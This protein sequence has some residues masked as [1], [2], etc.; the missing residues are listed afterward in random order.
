MTSKV[1]VRL[2]NENQ[3]VNLFRA[4]AGAEPLVVDPEL[5]VEWTAA[6]LDGSVS[7]PQTLAFSEFVDHL[8]NE[9]PHS[10]QYGID[11]IVSGTNIITT[12]V[13]IPSKQ[14][15]QIAQ[16]LPFMIEDQLAQDVSDQ[17][18]VVG[19]RSDNGML[20][21][22]AAPV[23]LLEGIQKLFDQHELPLDSVLPDML[24]LPHRENEWTILFEG[25]HLL[26]KKGSHS[27]L[28]IEMDAVPVVLASIIEHWED[29]PGILRILFCMKNLNENVKNWIKTQI[30]GHVVGEEL[31][32]EFEEINSSDFMLICDH[33]HQTLGAKKPSYDLLQGRFATSARRR[34]PVNF[35]WQPIAALF[36]IFVIMYT[37]FLYTQ[38]WQVNREV[39]RVEAETKSLYKRLFPRDKRVVNV[40]RQMEQHIRSFQSS[41]GGDSFMTLL[42]LAGE[43]IHNSNRGKKDVVQPKRVAFDEDQGDL[44]L[45]LVVE[46]FGQLEQFKTRLQESSLAVETASATQDKE[47]VKA[48][49]TIRNERS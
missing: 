45:D 25:R 9:W 18:L 20:P 38:A 35:K 5:L 7:E 14:A 30:A 40:K 6:D 1:F 39:T 17:H 32:V 8:H 3:W 37:A 29:K 34:R 41:A 15:R 48:R 44:R 22:V 46:D 42:A 16:A 31:E 33:L 26:M 2:V 36:G 24:C 13:N 47:G 4:A 43:Q 19:P 49:L 21:V 11:L 23:F 28:A 27:G 12:E 10:Y